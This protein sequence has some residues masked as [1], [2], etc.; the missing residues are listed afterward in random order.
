MKYRKIPIL[1]SNNGAGRTLTYF[2]SSGSSL[3]SFV[4]VTLA[5]PFLARGQPDKLV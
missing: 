1:Q 5:P 2:I 4:G 3:S